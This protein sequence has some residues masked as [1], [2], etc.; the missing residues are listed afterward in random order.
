[1]AWK[2]VSLVLLKD[3]WGIHLTLLGVHTISGTVP[4]LCDHEGSWTKA[5]SAAAK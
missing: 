2:K 4:T 1:M 3:S 5:K